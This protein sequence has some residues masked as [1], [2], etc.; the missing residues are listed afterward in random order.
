MVFF[1]GPRQEADD[2]LV[3]SSGMNEPHEVIRKHIARVITLLGKVDDAFCMNHY[4]VAS[5]C[6][7]S[8]IQD[9][10]D[11]IDDIINTEKRKHAN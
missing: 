3:R 9:H 7:C 2:R 11:L 6:L 10:L 1:A 5:S 4:D 8:A